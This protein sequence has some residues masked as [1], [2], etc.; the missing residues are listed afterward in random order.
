MHL[1]APSSLVAIN[2]N[3]WSR[4]VGTTGHDRRNAQQSAAGWHRDVIIEAANHHRLPFIG[5]DVFTTAGGLMTLLCLI[6]VDLHALAAANVDRILKG[7]K[8]S[9][10]PADVYFGRG[11]TILLQRERIKR[12][13]IK[14]RRLQHQRQ[15][16]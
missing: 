1:T 8:P 2:R 5:V 3:T 13:T 4:S 7:E 11:Q 10:A 9:E 14:Q 12:Q 6:A 15:P 16:A